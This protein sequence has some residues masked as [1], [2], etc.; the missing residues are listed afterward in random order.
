MESS[1]N[2]ILNCSIMKKSRLFFFLCAVLALVSC[3]GSDDGFMM[4]GDPH[5]Y[6]V[7]FEATGTDYSAEASVLN[8]DN[9][10]LY[11]E[12]DSKDLKQPNI[13]EE[14]TGRKVYYTQDK[15][16]GFGAHGII[17]SKSGASLTMMVYEDGKEVYRNTVSVPDSDGKN[18]SRSLEFYRNNLIEK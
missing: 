11:D 13:S 18:K 8:T 3:G 7:V 14:F 4:K 9:V 16:V 17:M 1:D 15:V 2:Q 10:S 6:R 5:E 12:T